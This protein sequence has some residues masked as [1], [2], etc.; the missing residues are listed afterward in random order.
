MKVGRAAVLSLVI[1]IAGAAPVAAAPLAEVNRPWH[2]W[3]SVVLVASVVGLAGLL[4]LGYLV[5]VIMAKYGI[6]V[7]RRSTG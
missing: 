4:A 1:L 7:G 5:R 3:M 6:R 2:Y